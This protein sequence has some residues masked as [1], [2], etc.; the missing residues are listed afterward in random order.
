M[1]VA[2]RHLYILL[3]TSST[4]LD[5]TPENDDT[6]LLEEADAAEVP[7]RGLAV[8]TT[9]KAEYLIARPMK[10]RLGGPPL[11]PPL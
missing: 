5:G 9:Q 11:C 7:R 10:H 1:Q 8:V 6:V 4:T 3:G 2:T